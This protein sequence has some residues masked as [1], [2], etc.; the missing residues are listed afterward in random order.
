MRLYGEEITCGRAWIILF[1]I[2]IVIGKRTS[3]AGLKFRTPANRLATME[4]LQGSVWPL[5]L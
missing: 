3:A 4:L 2:G 5:I 1:R